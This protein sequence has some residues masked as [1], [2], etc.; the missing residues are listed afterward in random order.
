MKLVC[1]L[2]ALLV[3]ALPISSSLAAI[4]S[5]RDAY[6]ASKGARNK[7]LAECNNR[8][9]R[10]NLGATSV[11]RKNFLRDCLRQRG[12]QRPAVRFP[13]HHGFHG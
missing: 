1:A 9:S 11:K 4:D 13:K 5:A 12:F 2:A 3:I 8:A 6:A 10:R 7:V